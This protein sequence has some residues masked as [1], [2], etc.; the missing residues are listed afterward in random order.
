MGTR[1]AKHR[2]ESSLTDRFVGAVGTRA[3]LFLLAAAAIVFDAA[4]RLTSY[5]T[6]GEGLLDEPAHLAMAGLV[7]VVVAKLVD[8]PPSSLSRH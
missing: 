5:S 4:T 8:L 2:R 7:L 1:L 3:T 6:L